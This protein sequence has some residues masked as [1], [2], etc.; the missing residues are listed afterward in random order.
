MEAWK[1]TMQRYADI[2]REEDLMVGMLQV[3]ARAGRA[4]PAPP[5]PGSPQ[6]RCCRRPLQEVVGGVCIQ[7]RV[8]IFV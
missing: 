8:P 4:V 6:P 1:E 2:A 7:I 3:N 5:G